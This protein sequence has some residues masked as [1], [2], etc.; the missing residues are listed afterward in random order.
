MRILFFLVFYSMLL[1][2]TEKIIEKPEDLISKDKMVNIVYDLAIMTAA[3]NISP[4]VLEDYHIET[5]NY[6]FTKYKIDSVQFVRS[7]LYYASIPTEYLAIYKKV[8]SR[9]EKE[10]KKLEEARKRINDSTK[11][12]MEKGSRTIVPKINGDSLP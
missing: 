5:M 9:L 6:L 2:C 4:A 8:D 12:V 1:S 3:K 10:Q 11:Q 7:D